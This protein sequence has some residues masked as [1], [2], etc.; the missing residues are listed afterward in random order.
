MFADSSC[1]ANGERQKIFSSSL[2]DLHICASSLDKNGCLQRLILMIKITH[3]E[4]EKVVGFLLV[5]HVSGGGQH[6]SLDPTGIRLF[7]EMI[8]SFDFSEVR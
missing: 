2:I 5:R 8:V 7:L 4:I 3:N 1:V 6:L